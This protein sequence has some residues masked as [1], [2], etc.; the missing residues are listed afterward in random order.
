MGYEYVYDMSVSFG[1]FQVI[2]VVDKLEDSL[3]D[4]KMIEHF[5][6]KPVIDDKSAGLFRQ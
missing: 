2:P 1:Q 3:P 5:H 4:G 6:F